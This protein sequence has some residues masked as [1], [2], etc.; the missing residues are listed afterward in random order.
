MDTIINLTTEYQQ[1]DTFPIESV[2]KD[3]PELSQIVYNRPLCYLDNAASTLKPQTVID[4]VA[5]FYATSY[6]NIHRGVY[7]TSQQATERYE[8]VRS[9]VA[10]Y[11]GAQYSSEIIF[12]R[13]AT[14]AI[15]L[16]AYSWGEKYIREGDEIIISTMEHHANIVPWQVLC[17][18]KN[19]QLR[20]MP[21]TDN[22]EI[23]LEEYEK[24]LSEKTK[25]VACVYASN[26]LGTINPIQTMIR[27]AKKVGATVLID[28]AQAIQH[29]PVN[30]QTLDCDFFVFSGHKVY[31]PSGTGVLYGKKSLLQSMPPYQTGG[32]MIRRVTFEKTTYADIP[33]RFEAGTPNIEGIIGLGEALRYVQ[34]CG[35]TAIAE[36]E[37]YLLEYAMNR[38]TEISELRV[39]G[40]AKEKVAVIS[41]TL[42]MIHPHDI[43]SFLDREGVAVRAGHHC[44]QPLWQRL[45]VNSTTRASFAFY[46]TEQEIDTLVDG[47]KKVIALFG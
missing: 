35:F 33:A 40:T 47:L 3:F 5:D 45:G 32:D 10:E 8:Y 31:A 20:I 25:L 19:A 7:I 26:A 23:I 28:G 24:L 36:R 1:S 46:N 29:I 13:G 17:E 11:I 43:G 39:W 22:G 37:A 27:M 14:E 42:D 4:T 30:V 9:V 44:T 18:K 41:F 12:T 21:I 38:L 34:K 6:S 15:N 16:V 2:R